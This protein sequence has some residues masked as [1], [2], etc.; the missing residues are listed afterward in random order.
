MKRVEN[1]KLFVIYLLRL[2]ISEADIVSNKQQEQKLDEWVIHV[3]DE[4]GKNWI[5]EME[6][7]T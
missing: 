3:S 1:I 7:E 4:L 2:S 6:I 5:I